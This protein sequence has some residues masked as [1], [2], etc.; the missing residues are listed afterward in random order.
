MG[1]KQTGNDDGDNRT[2]EQIIADKLR[3]AGMDQDGGG[4]GG[5]S[6]GKQ[7]YSDGGG[8]GEGDD[9]PQKG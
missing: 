4:K 6:G 8:K 3:D 7:G 9:A 2:D 5:D 1:E